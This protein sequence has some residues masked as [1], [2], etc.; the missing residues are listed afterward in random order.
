M[1][2]KTINGYTL[3]EPFQNKNAGFS[4]WTFGTRNGREYFIKEFQDPVYPDETT[5]TNTLRENRIRECMEFEHQKTRLYGALNA[6]SDGNVVRTVE[7]FRY[8]SRYYLATLRVPGENISMEELAVLPIQ[9]RLLLCRAVAHSLMRVHR[10]GI[11]HSDIKPSNVLLKRTKTGKLTTKLIDFDAGFFE[12]TPP[13]DEEELH[14]DQVYLAPEGG[15]FLYGEP[16]ELTCKMDVFSLGLLMHQYLTGELPHFSPEYDTAFE[17][18]LEDCPL[19]LDPGLPADVRVILEGMLQPEPEQRSSMEK[20]FRELEHFFRI[21][22][23]K[24]EE[25]DTVV[26]DIPQPPEYPEPPKDPMGTYFTEAG[27]L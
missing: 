21:R 16:V 26:I 8:G 3:L 19:E 14:F 2:I 1:E 12:D 20:V 13:E 17:A 22:K 10:V 7:F 24:E 5:L 4:R 11:V 6:A 9:E 15:R 18:V 25:E 27:D 23:P